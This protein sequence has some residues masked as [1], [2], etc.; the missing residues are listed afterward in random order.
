[1]GELLTDIATY[2]FSTL[3]IT[4]LLC[5]LCPVLVL[6][7]LLLLYPE[8]HERRAEW[9][10]EIS[11]VPYRERLIW[12][13]SLIPTA[14]FEAIPERARRRV[15]SPPLPPPGEEVSLENALAEPDHMVDGYVRVVYDKSAKKFVPASAVGHDFHWP[16]KTLP[17]GW[18]DKG[19]TRDMWPDDSEN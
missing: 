8:G 2:G 12:V 11:H 17:T 9:L 7:L 14:F 13:A 6:R 16:D 15:V 19:T 4:A 5:G 1:M 10:L 3:I 18:L